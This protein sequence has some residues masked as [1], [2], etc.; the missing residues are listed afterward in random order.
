[1][2]MKPAL[3]AKPKVLAVDDNRANLLAL[4]AALQERERQIRESEEVVRA[5]IVV[6]NVIEH[7]KVEKDFE[8]RITSLV[9]LGI[10]LEQSHRTPP[11]G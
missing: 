1:M 2:A 3:D 10:E 9:S 7:K 6:Q 5:V 11:Q 4:D 8:Q